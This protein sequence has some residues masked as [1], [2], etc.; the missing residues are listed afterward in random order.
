MLF[1]VRLTFTNGDIRYAGKG[2]WAAAKDIRYVTTEKSAKGKAC[3]WWKVS[4]APYSVIS[5]SK[6][7]IV[8]VEVTL[9]DDQ[10]ESIPM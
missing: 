6:I 1:V 2:S 9:L 4:N 8:P 5:F 7:E 3:W 10:A